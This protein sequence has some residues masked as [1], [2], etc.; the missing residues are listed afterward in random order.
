[1]HLTVHVGVCFKEDLSQ[2]L[3]DDGDEVLSI[4]SDA[5]EDASF[6]NLVRVRLTL[7]LCSTA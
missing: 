6:A 7:M 2:I 3:A 5:G 1:M 4:S